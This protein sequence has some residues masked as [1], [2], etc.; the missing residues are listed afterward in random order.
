MLI[1]M[2]VLGM[3]KLVIVQYKSS[4]LYYYIYYEINLKDLT[5]AEQ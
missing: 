2:D 3:K 4:E 5:L 1:R